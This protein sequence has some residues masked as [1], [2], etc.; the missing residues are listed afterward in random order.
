SNTIYEPSLGRVN[1]IAVSPA[2]SN[3]ILVGAGSGGVWLSTDGG[4]TWD[5]RGD[6]LPVLGVSDIEFAA[7]DPNIAYMTTGDSN[8]AATPSVGVYKSTD[9]GFNWYATGL[10]FDPANFTLMNKIAV[11]PSNPNIV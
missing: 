6:F 5:P 3:R 2:N 9:G 1:A 11:D 7:S 10:V 4:Q 8:A